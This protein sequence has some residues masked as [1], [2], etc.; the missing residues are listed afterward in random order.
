MS[1]EIKDYLERG[2]VV[3]DVRTLEEW[4]EGHVS[5]SKHIVLTV[6][7]LELEQIKSWGKPVIAVCRSG[8]RS[9]QAAQF[10]NQNG[11]KI[12]EQFNVRPGWSHTGAVAGDS[13]GGFWV[14]SNVAQDAIYLKKLS[15]D[16]VELISDIKI[17]SDAFQSN[18]SITVLNDQ[19]VLVTWSEVSESGSS[20]IFGQIVSGQGDVQGAVFQLN[21]TGEYLFTINNGGNAPVTFT[22]HSATPISYFSVSSDVSNPSNTYIDINQATDNADTIYGSTSI[23]VEAAFMDAKLLSSYSPSPSNVIDNLT[24]ELWKENTQVG[25]DVAITKGEVLVDSTTDFDQVRISQSDAFDTNSTINVFDVL[26]TVESIVGISTLTGSAKQAADVN[27][28]SNVNVF[29]VLAMVEHIVGVS[30]I[31]HFD[32]VDSSGDRITQLTSITSGDV[33]EYHLVMNGDVNMDGAFNE[34]YITTVDIV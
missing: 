34:G 9:G 31:D 6:I 1:T 16:G 8:A 11:S 15:V 25:G 24:I 20:D 2:A 33:P 7:P 14:A 12:G 13:D 32:M 30:S 23:S 5:G 18:P 4:N 28:D 26:L 29:D 27:N 21:V 10:L 19:R 3:L 22:V 17:D